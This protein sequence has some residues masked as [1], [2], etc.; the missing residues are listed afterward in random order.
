MIPEME[1]SEYKDR[2]SQVTYKSF[3][4]FDK[5]DLSTSTELS[6][7][8]EIRKMFLKQADIVVSDGN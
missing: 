6:Y 5:I 7:S 4:L 2:T 8:S 1:F 3:R